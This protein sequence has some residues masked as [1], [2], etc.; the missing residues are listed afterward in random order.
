[1]SN[2]INKINEVSLYSGRLEDAAEEM[3]DEIYLHE[4]PEHLHSYIDYKAFTRDCEYSSDFVEF[5]FDSETYTCT[6]AS[7]V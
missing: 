6:N 3:F 2:A 1:M 5:E 7:A 4:I